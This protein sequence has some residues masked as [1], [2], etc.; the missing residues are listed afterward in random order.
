MGLGCDK[1]TPQSRSICVPC[2]IPNLP[3]IK[4]VSCGADFTFCIDCED[5]AWSFGRNSFGQLGTGNTIDLFVPH[6]ILSIPPV[7]SVA[8]GML[9]T[10]I[11]TTDSNL[12]SCGHNNYGQLCLGNQE[13]QKLTF[14]QTQFSN[15]SRIS[16]GSHHSLFGN[17]KGEIYSCGLNETGELGLGH[18]NST[19]ITPMLIPNLPSNIVQ[20]ICGSSNSLFLDSDGNVY[21]TGHNY[22][23]QLGLAHKTNQK[24]L[25]QIPNIPPIQSISCID[26]STFLIDF[27][28]NLW[29]FGYNSHGQLGHGDTTNRNVP[30]KIES[31]KNIKKISYG[32]RGRHFTAKDSNNT[33]FVA[34]FNT[35]GQLGTGDTELVSIPKELDSQ[36]FTIWGDILH[37]RAKSARK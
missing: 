18:S 15:I 11:I 29:S 20:F 25:N 34:G 16:A 32:T 14:Q 30:T 7:L 23:G 28:G 8:C 5:F 2:V 22:F 17:E 27:D 9:H 36:Y 6:K 26:F 10:L 24:K 33:I 37:S 35:H 1:N 21:S 12:W 31:L 3:S 19:Q 4:Q 13:K